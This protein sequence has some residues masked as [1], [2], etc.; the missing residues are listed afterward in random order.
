MA[1][2]TTE[3]IIERFKK[4]HGDNYDYSL[5]SYKHSHVK[6]K[7]VCKKHGEFE[8]L[9]NA[10]IRGQGCAKCMYDSKRANFSK[11]IEKFKL[12]HG[13]R[14]DYS[15]VVYENISERV[16]IICKEHG[17]FQQAPYHHIEGSGCP[18]CIGRHKTQDEVI[19]NF[20]D[21]HG[22][23]Y[24]YSKVVYEKALKKVIII[25]PIHGEFKQTPQKHISGQGCI[26]CA[27]HAMLTHDEIMKRFIR[28]HG[29]KYD[30]S[31]VVGLK[32]SAVIKIICPLHGVFEQS[33]FLHANGC[34]CQKCGGSKQLTTNEVINQFKK[35]HGDKYDYSKV[36]YTQAFG[37]VEIICPE[38]GSF[39]QIAKTHK[40]GGGCPSCAVTIGHTKSS[41]LSY[42]KKFGGKT[43]LYLIKCFDD[44][45]IF[46]KIGIARKGAADRFNSKQKLPY[47]FELLYQI[48]GDAK[49]MWDLEKMLHKRIKHNKYRPL[50]KFNGHTEC[51]SQIDDILKILK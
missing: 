26:K 3:Q 49:A 5:V 2:Y 28:A 13:N 15:L 27:G 17:V 44:S 50:K 11:I 9:V 16:K 33:A 18:K 47:N 21:K 14:Y 19:A 37:K 39:F 8:Q 12:V 31:L 23:K 24:D 22:N 6:V 36:K 51:F 30:Y 20:K 38:H 7:I 4:T 45:E 42:C 41:Y 29:N 25:C 43:H 40:G 46:F 35:M 1:K 10:H 34:G 48:E 32:N